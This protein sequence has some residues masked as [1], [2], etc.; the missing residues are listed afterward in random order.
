MLPKVTYTVI[1]GEGDVVAYFACGEGLAGL[2]KA[3]AI[4]RANEAA[5]RPVKVTFAKA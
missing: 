4:A 1:V 2:T 3:Q 5:G